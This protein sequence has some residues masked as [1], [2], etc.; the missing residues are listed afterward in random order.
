MRGAGAPLVRFAV[1]HARTHGGQRMIAA[2]TQVA[3]VRF[4]VGL[5]WSAYRGA[6]DYLG[7][8]HQPMDIALT[9]C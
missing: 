9:D 7:I 2:H 4:F 6:E 3:N 8:T 5:G 1:A